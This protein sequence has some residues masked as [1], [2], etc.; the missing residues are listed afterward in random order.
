MKARFN[1]SSWARV[2]G[3]MTSSKMRSTSVA[4]KPSRVIV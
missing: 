3:A 2:A 1:G 4:G